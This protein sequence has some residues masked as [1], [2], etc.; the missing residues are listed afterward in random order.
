MKAR[1]EIA[2]KEFKVRT[3][4]RFSSATRRVLVLGFLS[5]VAFIS[6]APMFTPIDIAVPVEKSSGGNYLFGLID[7]TKRWTEWEIIQG[8]AM[9]R[10]SYDQIMLSIFSFYVG[11]SA[12]KR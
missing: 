12:V 1:A 5:M 8:A 3:Q 4:D 11:S 6:L 10:S 9:F 7:T 2:D